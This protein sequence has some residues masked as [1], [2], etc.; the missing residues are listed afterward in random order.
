[1]LEVKENECSV[2]LSTDW[3]IPTL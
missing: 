3:D 2:P 1:L